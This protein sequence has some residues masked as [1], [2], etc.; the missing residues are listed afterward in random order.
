MYIQLQSTA[1]T[2]SDPEV[3]NALLNIPATQKVKLQMRGPA[4]TEIEGVE[5]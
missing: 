1:F 2:A 3:K 5:F 4:L